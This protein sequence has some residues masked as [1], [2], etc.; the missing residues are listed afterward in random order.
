[1]ERLAALAQSFSPT[2]EIVGADA[3]VLAVGPLRRLFGPP[4][5]IAAE[6]ARE[7]NKIKLDGNIAI[8]ADPDTAILA[9]RNLPGVTILQPGHEMDALAHLRLEALPADA[10]TVAVLRRWGVSTLGQF[11]ELPPDGVMERLG[12]RGLDLLRL[13]RG[14][15]SRP[16]RPDR[17]T[18]SYRAR[19]EPEHPVKLLE[20]LSFLLSR[21]LNELCGKLSRQS[22]AAS[23]TRLHL[24]LENKTVYSRVLRLPFPTRDA[25]TLLKLL[26]LDLEAHPPGFAVTAVELETPPVAPRV[27]QGD[28]YEPPKP[29]PEKL[30]LTLGKIRAMVGEG[31]VGSPRPLDTHRR[32]AWR[33]L[34]SPPGPSAVLRRP[35]SGTLQMAFRYWR[36]PVPASVE[37]ENGT[38]RRVLS[39]AARGNVIQAAGPWRGSGD[40]WNAQ[41]WDR[42]E[43]DLSLTDGAIY[44]I[45]WIVKAREWFLEGYYD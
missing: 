18:E 41:A 19:F 34:A 33:M 43:W 36:P 42:E 12:A 32:D 5:K 26:Q 37:V 22:M 30:E 35:P 15:R 11:R 4:D 6:I 39:R 2:V 28:L 16:L 8:A 25:R 1:M 44:R 24:E 27:T 21:L 10:E 17:Q 13:I 23:E 7:A 38:P 20:P 40:W 3:V 31:N 45:A 9:A 29:E 14:E